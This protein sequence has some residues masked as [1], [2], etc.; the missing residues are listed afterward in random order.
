MNLSNQR[1]RRDH[2]ARTLIDLTDEK[3]TPAWN[4]EHQK[5][6]DTAMAEIADIDASIKRHTAAMNVIGAKDGE[7]GFISDDARNE[8][9]RTPGAHSSHSAALRNFMRNGLQ[10]LDADQMQA[11]RARQSV[12]DIASA[13]LLPQAAMSTTTGSEGGFTVAQ[14]YYRQL[15]EAQKMF[16]GIR[17]VAEIMQTGTGATMN[18]SATDATSE[19]GEIL[20]QNTPGSSQDTVLQNITLDVFKY[21]SKDIALPF[22]LIQ[23]SMFDL[24][25]Y[26][27]K[28]L[29]L[30]IG[31]ITSQHFT[32]GTGTAQPRGI[33]TA[34]QAGKIGATG[35]TTTVTY[36]DLVNL[37]HAVDPIYRNQANVGY[38]MHDQSLKVVRTLKDTQGRPIFVPG[39]E[40]GN[41]GGAP[42]RLMGR[43]IYISQEMPTMAANAK[44]ILFGLFS[45]YKIREVMDLTLFRFTDSAYIKKGQIGF[46]AMNRQGGNL[47][48]VG[49]AVKHYQNSAT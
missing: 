31:R 38:M 37:E 28:L 34:A 17:K 5:K 10:G 49:G 18:F 26:I 21:G 12:G 43:P 13:M 45:E 23:D 6:Y 46:M 1:E 2:L 44:S 41:P 32:V 48:D 16:G 39:Y 40:I 36:D 22:E 33:V 35:Q 24:D 20:G 47:I 8:F 7:N 14:E 15:T 11:M 25:A 19:T 29:G 3:K 9:T 42:D 4:D 30:R 27:S